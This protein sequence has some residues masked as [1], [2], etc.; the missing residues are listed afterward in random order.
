MNDTENTEQEPEN[1]TPA[2]DPGATPEDSTDSAAEP[3]DPP[4]IVQGGGSG[5]P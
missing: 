4:I 2:S 1:E 3:V 5:N